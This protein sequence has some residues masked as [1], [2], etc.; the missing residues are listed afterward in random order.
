M[1]KGSGA[2]GDER[3][4]C[5]NPASGGQFCDTFIQFGSQLQALAAPQKVITSL[6]LVVVVVVVVDLVGVSTNCH[7]NE[8]SF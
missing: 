7:Q 8:N 2:C 3:Q 6:M 4:L 1:R 5:I